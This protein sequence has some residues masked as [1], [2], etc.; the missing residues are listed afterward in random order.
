MRIIEDDLVEH[1]THEANSGALL[2]NHSANS[3]CANGSSLHQCFSEAGDIATSWAKEKHQ[4]A[5]GGKQHIVETLILCRNI[6]S[7]FSK[8]MVQTNNLLC[9]EL[10]EVL[11]TL[12]VIRGDV[13][14]PMGQKSCFL[15]YIKNFTFFV[16]KTY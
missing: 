14:A 9:W 12:Y 2:T 10:S 4:G 13:A 11:K 5:K 7:K 8:Q 16:N 15:Q 6:N 3:I 1:R